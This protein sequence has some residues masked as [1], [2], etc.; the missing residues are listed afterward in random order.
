[1]PCCKNILRKK[2]N[3]QHVNSVCKNDE[4]KYQAFSGNPIERFA[5]L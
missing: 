4:V 2:H 5:K 3:K 1:M